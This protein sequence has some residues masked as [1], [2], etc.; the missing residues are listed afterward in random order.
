M[1]QDVGPRLVQTESRIDLIQEGT[2]E[3]PKIKPT[4]KYLGCY[5]VKNRDTDFL[6]HK[7]PPS[8][9][10]VEKCY[11]FCHDKEVKNP[12]PAPPPPPPPSAPSK[13]PAGKGIMTLKWVDG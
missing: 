5:S 12:P 13:P 10:T 2:Q 6:K 8:G 4:Y 7:D 1:K 11:N 3:G 9:M